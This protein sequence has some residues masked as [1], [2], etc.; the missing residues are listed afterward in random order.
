MAA[1]STT[2]NRSELITDGAS[3][4]PIDEV[5][6]VSCLAFLRQRA[7]PEVFQQQTNLVCPFQHNVLFCAFCSGLFLIFGNINMLN[8]LLLFCEN[9][10]LLWP[11]V[12]F[13][14]WF[15]WK[16]SSAKKPKTKQKTK[17]P[18]SQ[19][20]FHF[21]VIWGSSPAFVLHPPRILLVTLLHH[22][23]LSYSVF[24]SSWSWRLKKLLWSTSVKQE[25]KAQMRVIL[26]KLVLVSMDQF[27]NI[28]TCL[29][30][31]DQT[32]CKR[33]P[34]LSPFIPSKGDYLGIY[35]L[36]EWLSPRGTPPISSRYLG[37]MA[38]VHSPGI[39]SILAGFYIP[40][41][42]CML[43]L[44]VLSILGSFLAPWFIFFSISADI[45]SLKTCLK[46]LVVGWGLI[47]VCQC[48][49]VFH[50]GDKR[51]NDNLLFFWINVSGISAQ[52]IGSG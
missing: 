8:I 14:K 20:C 27:R 31:I 9:H 42:Q 28:S 33:S 46:F 38:A 48:D 10:A 25:L 2:V 11:N 24:G 4:A 18:T 3:P 17:P 34:L 26:T 32:N 47:K 13:T 43:L 51:E 40:T 16:W 45:T 29:G 44:H 12:A 21:P 7:K 6:I 50:S 41:E 15:N 49:G 39:H 36:S 30:E 22:K 52:N 23:P 35:L 5:G 37:S 1:V 19:Q